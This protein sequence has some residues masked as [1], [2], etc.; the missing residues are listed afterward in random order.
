MSPTKQVFHW[1]YLTVLFQTYFTVM[2]FDNYFS[3]NLE[4]FL[5]VFFPN[6]TNTYFNI[7]ITP[8]FCYWQCV[9][10]VFLSLILSLLFIF[11]QMMCMKYCMYKCC[12]KVIFTES[13][14]NCQ[15][16]TVFALSLSNAFPYPLRSKQ[17][18]YNFKEI[19]QSFNA[20]PL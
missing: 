7:I 4:L 11:L 5:F 13:S 8:S 17:M 14:T 15:H 2:L 19:A 18:F 9:H 10:T 20:I 12:L 6:T 3:V 16:S 1:E